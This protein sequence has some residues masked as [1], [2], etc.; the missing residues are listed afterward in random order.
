[1]E[2]IVYFNGNFLKA[3][4][5]HLSIFDHGFLY[6]D[7]VFESIRV[8]QG[9]PFA[10]EDHMDRFFKSAADISIQVP[11]VRSVIL[12]AIEVLLDKNNLTDAQIRICLTRGEGDI[13]LD[14]SLCPN[15]TFVIIPHQ[16]IGYPREYFERG[17][18]IHMGSVTRVPT[19]SV[20]ATIKSHNYLANVLAKAQA[21]AAGCFDSVMINIEGYVAECSTSNI[22]LVQGGQV[23][24]PALT[25]GILEG[26]TRRAVMQLAEKKGIDVFETMIL[27]EEIARADECFLTNT[28][29]EILP[30]THCD[31]SPIGMGMPGAVTLTL[32][33]VFRQRVE[34]EI[35]IYR[36][37]QVLDEA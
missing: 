15:P 11:L 27:P 16:W 26:V 30:V 25:S 24:T 5:A 21:R 6:G 37:R 17:V 13:G 22:F 7:G 36:A 12:K 35:R 18:Q 31:G 34:E 14:T 4:D 8:Y 3:S 23:R 29:M 32:R 33:K 9:M 2:T 19:T 10:F 28:S 1:M 20:P